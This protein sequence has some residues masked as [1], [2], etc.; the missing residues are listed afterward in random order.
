MVR[1]PPPLPACILALAPCT[2]P[3]L[4]HT[5]LTLLPPPPP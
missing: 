4:P 5:P 2:A 1:A 3:P